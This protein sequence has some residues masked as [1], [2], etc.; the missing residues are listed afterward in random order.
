MIVKMQMFRVVREL[1][2]HFVRI[3][4]PGATSIHKGVSQLG[5]LRGS[6]LISLIEGGEGSTKR[7][8][9]RSEVS[10]G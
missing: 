1:E 3:C 5:Q 8:V 4:P 9:L 7:K 10:V 6:C 2:V